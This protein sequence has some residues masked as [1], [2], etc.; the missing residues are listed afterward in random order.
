VPY[1]IGMT[2]T[3]EMRYSA[4]HQVDAVFPLLEAS[5]LM[6]INLLVS[7]SS[8]EE[9]ASTC[10]LPG[11]FF[12]S[13]PVRLINVSNLRNKW[14]GEIWVIEIAGLDGNEDCASGT[15]KEMKTVLDCKPGRPLERK[16]SKTVDIRVIDACHKP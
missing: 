12:V 6:R 14:V 15:V 11:R 9:R 16:S 13:C 3:F 4:D 7:F 10:P 2:P 8:Q 5:T 1:P